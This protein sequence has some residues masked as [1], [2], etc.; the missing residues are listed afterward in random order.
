M[1]NEN[2][3][4]AQIKK[5][6]VDKYTLPTRD[7]LLEAF[8]L[9]KATPVNLLISLFNLEHGELDWDNI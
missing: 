8:E 2:K 7:Q 6:I 9:Y 3:I 4:I 1:E 5:L